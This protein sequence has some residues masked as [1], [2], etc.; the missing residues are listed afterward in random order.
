[1]VFKGRFFSSKKSDNSSPDG[2]SNSSRSFGSN[3][4]IRSDK[5]KAKSGSFG[6]KDGGSSGGSKKE[7][8]GKETLLK[9]SSSSQGR[10][11][12][13]HSS[14]FSSSLKSKRGIEVEKL[15]GKEGK[16]VGPTSPAVATAAV[17][18]I[19]ASSLGL[20]KIKTRSGP[21]PQESFLGFGSGR[22]R[23]KGSALGGSALSKPPFIGGEGDGGLSLGYGKKGGS[24]DGKKE[25]VMGNVENAGWID[26][27]SNSDSMSTESGA[28]DQ[29][30]H[31]QARPRLQ[32]AESSTEA[33]MVP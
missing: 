29:S 32:N 8:K 27:G 24:G 20:N 30:P 3:S 10:E 19:V 2:S 12:G 23:D 9:S 18:P 7:V 28:G 33:G 21:L 22:G 25:K 5:K 13:K 14:G 11:L 6:S 4:P 17:S 15:G 26:N 16:E 31:V 1:M